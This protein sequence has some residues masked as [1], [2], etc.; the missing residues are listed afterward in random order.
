[1][2]RNVVCRLLLIPSIATLCMSLT[3][4][5]ARAQNNSCSTAQA[6]GEWGFTLIGTLLTPT[7]TVPAAAIARGTFDTQ[8]NITSASEARNVGGG[9]ANETLTGSW[10]VNS[11]CTGSLTVYVYES[12]VLTRISVASLVFIDNMRE[13][14][15]VQQSLTLPG[16]ATLPVVITIDGKRLFPPN[17]NPQ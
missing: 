3:V 4:P 7:G 11:D 16:G 10:T 1:M 6:A 14:R 9:F 17:T 15:M 8:G 13:V 2:K 12:S 5:A